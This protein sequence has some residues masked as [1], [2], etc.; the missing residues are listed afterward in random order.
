LAWDGKSGKPKMVGPFAGV[1]V[2]GDYPPPAGTEPA[3][4]STL[5]LDDLVPPWRGPAKEG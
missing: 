2:E 4:Q 1:T 5:G 3:G